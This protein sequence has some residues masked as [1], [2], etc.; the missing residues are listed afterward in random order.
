MNK[1]KR[2]TWA[3]RQGVRDVGYVDGQTITLEN[4]FAGEQYDRFDALA[5]IQQKVA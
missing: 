4:R 1:K 2:S 3:H 5:T